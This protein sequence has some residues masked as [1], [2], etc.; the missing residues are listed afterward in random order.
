MAL[1]IICCKPQTPPWVEW[2]WPNSLTDQ[3][4]PQKNSIKSGSG[5]L[6]DCKPL[7]C[8]NCGISANKEMLTSSSNVYRTFVQSYLLFNSFPARGCQS[9]PAFFSIFIKRSWPPENVVVWIS[10]HAVCQKKNWESNIFNKKLSIFFFSKTI[11]RSY[12]EWS[13]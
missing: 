3:M 10:E 1:L 13:L 8:G 6:W 9:S 12:T 5:I 2:G 7:D 4:L 11:S